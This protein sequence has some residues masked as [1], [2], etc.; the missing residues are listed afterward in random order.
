MEQSSDLT[1]DIIEEMGVD[2]FATEDL[3][4]ILS[5]DSNCRSARG[6]EL[7]K[8][9]IRKH[10][11]LLRNDFN[12]YHM[13]EQK[14][15]QAVDMLLILVEVASEI[16]GTM[17]LP[18]EK[19]LWSFV[20]QNA[21]LIVEKLSRAV[22]LKA[23]QE[24]AGKYPWQNPWFYRDTRVSCERGLVSIVQMA[25]S[26]L[27][28]N[29]PEL[30]LAHIC[31]PH[32]KTTIEPEIVLHAMEKLPVSYANATLEW[33]ISNFEI[34]AFDETSDEKTELSAC[35]RVIRR[36]SSHCDDVLFRRMEELIY[37]CC[38]Q[39]M[40]CAG[41]WN[42]DSSCA[43]IVIGVITP[44]SGAICRCCC[45]PRWIL[46]AFREIQRHCWPFLGENFRKDHICT[47]TLK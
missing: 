9:L 33:L 23:D 14:L 35:Q 7:R 34:N 22:L 11:E 5:A 28:E 31:E 27:A 17:Y 32:E 19:K 43:R 29:E 44:R 16:R 41:L 13:I 36:F 4:D 25:N 37:K 30:F 18:D 21:V 39:K 10:N 8:E 12:I 2:R 42:I 24:S 46:S 3:Y 6:F 47:T 15:P 45:F 20:A 40:R 26:W 38:P 1:V